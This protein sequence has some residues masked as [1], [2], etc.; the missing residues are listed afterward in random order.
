MSD[1]KGLAG[2][3]E[4]K[5]K[6]QLEESARQDQPDLT[7]STTSNTPAKGP[8]QKKRK[9]GKKGTN[10]TRQDLNAQNPKEDGIDESIGKMDGKLLSDYLAQRA[11]KQDKELS[12]VELNDLSVPGMRTNTFPGFYGIA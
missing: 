2:K 3:L 4:K 8:S 6:R 10:Q 9:K 7:P 12:A 5:R 1:Q 11:Q